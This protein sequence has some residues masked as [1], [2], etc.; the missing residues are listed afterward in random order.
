MAN[1]TANPYV[2]YHLMRDE[3]DTMERG[4]AAEDMEVVE[5]YRGLLSNAPRVH[6]S[7][8]EEH[9]QTASLERMKRK[10]V[11]ALQLFDRGYYEKVCSVDAACAAHVI[12]MTTDINRLWYTNSNKKI[13]LHAVRPRSTAHHDLIFRFGKPFLCMPLGFIDLKEQRYETG[14]V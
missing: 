13:E 11:S 7:D 2:V 1:E 5:L 8:L 4:A 6:P 12:E 14:I 9:R 3:L 10:C